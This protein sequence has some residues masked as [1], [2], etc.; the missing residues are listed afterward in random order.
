[1]QTYTIDPHHSSISFAVRGLM[2]TMGTLTHIVGTVI[3]DAQ[4]APASME[5]SVAA[6]SL[7]TRLLLRDMHLKTATFLDVRRYPAITYRS[8]HFERVAVNR[9]V[10]DG[11][12]RFHGQEHPIRLEAVVESDSEEGSSYRAHVSGVLP[13]AAFRVPRNPLLRVLLLP[14]IGDNVAIT[15]EIALTLSVETVGVI[16]PL[17]TRQTQR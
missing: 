2:P 7:N 9:F 3:A 13:R 16:S 6:H 1:M 8:D 5:V 4:G 11:L 10:V 17:A 14:I 15:A 12:L